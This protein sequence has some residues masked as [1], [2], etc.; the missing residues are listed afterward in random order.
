MLTPSSELIYGGVWRAI[1]GARIKKWMLVGTIHFQVDMLVESIHC[2]ILGGICLL[3]AK[4]FS[5]LLLDGIDLEE[6]Y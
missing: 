2:P 1:D 5:L 6:R 4:Q 3:W